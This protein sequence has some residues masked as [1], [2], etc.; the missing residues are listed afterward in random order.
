VSWF[1][2]SKKQSL[3]FYQ[4]FL[5]F[6]AFFYQKRK[7]EKLYCALLCFMQYPTEKWKTN[8]NKHILFWQI[9]E[10][11]LKQE[12]NEILILP[13]NVASWNKNYVASQVCLL[14]CIPSY[15]LKE[16][17]TAL[18]IT[19]T[20]IQFYLGQKKRARQKW[21]SCST[22]IDWKSKP[23]NLKVPI[24]LNHQNI[25][26]ILRIVFNWTTNPPDLGFYCSRRA[27]V[28]WLYGNSNIN[29]LHFFTLQS[30]T[31]CR[32]ELCME[33]V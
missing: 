7:H 9:L 19:H 12:K 10:Q 13:N 15:E 14:L 16:I 30:I 31:V 4:N 20:Y 5:N 23:N 11:C 3:I 26:F 21:T 6:E 2:F 17:H 1:F 29:G 24:E 32:R 27:S 28:F 18:K 33:I 8:L 25:I 22:Q